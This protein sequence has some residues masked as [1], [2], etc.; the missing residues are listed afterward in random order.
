[1]FGA[2]LFLPL[3]SRALLPMLPTLLILGTSSNPVMWKYQW[4]YPLALVPFVFWGL[5]E[6]HRSLPVLRGRPRWRESVFLAA[7]LVFPLAGA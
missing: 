4:Y 3:L 2:A 6:S 5:V 7:L 1:M